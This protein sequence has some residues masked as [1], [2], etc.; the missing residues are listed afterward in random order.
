MFYTYSQNNTH[1]VF[2]GPE[3]VI[4]EADNPSE[5]DEIAQRECSLYFDG[6]AS[7][8]DCSCCGDRWYSPYEDGTEKPEIYGKPA[9]TYARENPRNHVI[10][11]YKDG[12]Q[13]SFKFD[14]RLWQFQGSAE[15]GRLSGGEKALYDLAVSCGLKYELTQKDKGLLVNTIYY[16][17]TGTPNQI[18]VFKKGLGVLQEQFDEVES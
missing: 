4:V 6:V 11:R 17:V 10:V 9:E 15:V 12:R 2:K 7:G 18:K 5:S 8:I 13:D 14:H 3:Y 1:G 16:T